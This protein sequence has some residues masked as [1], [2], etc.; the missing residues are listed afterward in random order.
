VRGIGGIGMERGWTR[1]L[2]WGLAALTLALIV[3]QQAMHAA[4]HSG[5]GNTSVA[6]QVA[7]SAAMLVFS[8]VG[9]LVVTN[10]PGNPLGWIFLGIGLLGG[11]VIGAVD[12]YATHGL[13][14]APGSAPGALFAAWVYG[15]AWYATVGLIAFVPLLYPTGTV[16]GPRWRFVLRALIVMVAGITAVFMF[17]PGPIGGTD[18]GLPDNPVGIAALKSP[19]AAA[20]AVITGSLAVLL[21]VAVLSMIV[22]FRGAR[23]DERQQMKWMT[24]AA[25]VLAVGLIVPS[26]VGLQGAG[27]VIFAI[28]V[29]Q[30]PLA[31]GVAML[32]Y[33][34]YD[35]DTLINRTLVY[36]VVT[37]LLGA[38]Y[39]GLVV[40]GQAVSTS[41]AGGG[42]IA[43]TVS[44][45]VVAALFLPLRSRVQ[46]FVDRRFYRRRYDAGQTLE[47]FG[48]HL[49][50]EVDLDAL[51]SELC[52]AV[53]DTM[54]PRHVGLW[55]RGNAGSP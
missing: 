2:A 23:G 34:L 55:L 49:R 6:T 20:D 28:S 17:Y 10:V 13:V 35:V 51:G 14:D 21:A 3:A 5:A 54:Q 53:T 33:R 22:R 47:R 44:T 1:Y 30:L 25:V 48:R 11:G 32:R 43:I 39:V 37:A 50:D 15:W 40:V 26:A 24:F 8:V 31:V 16:P 52:A 7:F 12:V 46:R 42:T 41:L 18:S 29:V 19:S 36:G 27:D 38:A 9:A 4:W 45:L